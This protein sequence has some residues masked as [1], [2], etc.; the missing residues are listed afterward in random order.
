MASGKTSIT[1]EIDATIENVASRLLERMG[2]S[3][4]AAIE[5]FYRRIISSG[6]D[7]PFQ[8]LVEATLAELLEAAIWENN[9]EV[10]DVGLDSEGNILIDK[11]K[12]PD[13]YDWAVNG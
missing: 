13:L 8:S 1:I 6:G 5:M 12:H 2:L 7:L 10:V 3:Q 11:D 9:P 4:A